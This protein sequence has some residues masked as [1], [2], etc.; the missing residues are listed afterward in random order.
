MAELLRGHGYGKSGQGGDGMNSPDPRL[1]QPAARRW[2]R[3]Y[4]R[5]DAPDLDDCT[6][7]ACT[8]LGLA[9]ADA[10]DAIAHREAVRLAVERAAAR[11]DAIHALDS[12]ESERARVG[13][14]PRP[15]LRVERG[16]PHARDRHTYN[17]N[18]YKGPV[19]P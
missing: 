16:L 2:P 6:C 14:V 1:P 10:R 15:L 18:E 8:R 19:V 3:P 17:Q 4:L 11:V 13:G 5:Q 9:L 7:D 12:R